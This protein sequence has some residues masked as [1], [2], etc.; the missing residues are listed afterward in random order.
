MV[1][2]SAIS[3]GDLQL[4]G[5]SLLAYS[6][7]VYANGAVERFWPAAVGAGLM[8][9]FGLGLLL[10]AAAAAPPWYPVAGFGTAAVL[11]A[12]QVPCE[13]RVPRPSVWLPEHRLARL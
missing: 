9:A 12:L 6:V 10:D 3:L 4:A 11:Y 2:V 5:E 1:F 8:T 7:V 13:R